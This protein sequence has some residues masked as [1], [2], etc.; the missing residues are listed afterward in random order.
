MRK[1]LTPPLGSALQSVIANAV[2]LSTCKRSI[3]QLQQSRASVSVREQLLPTFGWQP[4]LV[5]GAPI[6][7]RDVLSDPNRPDASRARFC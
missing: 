2:N 6:I 7:Y 1:H 3:R 5:L 4:L